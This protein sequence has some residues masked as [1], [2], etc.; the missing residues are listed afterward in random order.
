MPPTSTLLDKSQNLLCAD[1]ASGTEP[2][3]T[4]TTG[5]V[6]TGSLGMVSRGPCAH[7]ALQ[8]KI[9]LPAN[10]RRNSDSPKPVRNEA[11]L[12]ADS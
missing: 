12:P 1:G 6:G 11:L 7:A 3:W 8:K 9:R 5:L 10:N 2:G 4:I